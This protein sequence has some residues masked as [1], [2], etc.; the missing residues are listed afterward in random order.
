MFVENLDEIEEITFAFKTNSSGGLLM[1]LPTD[2][3]TLLLE[4]EDAQV[5]VFKNY[6]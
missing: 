6:A 4:L 3:Q 2:G 5:A 1:A